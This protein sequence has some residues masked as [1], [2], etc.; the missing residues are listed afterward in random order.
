MQSVGDVVALA[1]GLRRR[2][3]AAGFFSR[4]PGGEDVEAGIRV[5]ECVPHHREGFVREPFPAAEQ[6]PSAGPDRV[7]LPPRR[8]CVSRTTR[9]RTS[10]SISLP[11]CR[12]TD[13]I[14]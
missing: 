9:C 3:Q 4:D 1:A 11:S 8:P 7:G 13:Q 10:V 14:Q 2:E 12:S 5:E 6:S